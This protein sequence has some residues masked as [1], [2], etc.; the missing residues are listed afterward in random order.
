[1]PPLTL[2]SFQLSKEINPDFSFTQIKGSTQVRP[3]KPFNTIYVPFWN[4]IY[5]FNFVTPSKFRIRHQ[6]GIIEID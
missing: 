5:I 4:N 1:M 6:I 3:I 2:Q